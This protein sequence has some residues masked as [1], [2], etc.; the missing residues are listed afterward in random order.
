MQGTTVCHAL[1]SR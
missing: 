1:A